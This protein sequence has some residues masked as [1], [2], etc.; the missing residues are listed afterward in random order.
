MQPYSWSPRVARSAGFSLIEAAVVLLI[1]G[2]LI[3][4]VVRPLL[5][6]T[7]NRVAEETRRVMADAREALLGYVVS[8]GYFPCP[9]DAASNGNEA[10]GTDHNTG[11]CPSSYGF[12]PAVSLGITSVDAQGYAVDGGRQTPNRVRYAVSNQTIVGIVNPFTTRFGMRR[13]G[14]T[15]LDGEAQFFICGSG[16]GVTAGADCGTAPTLTS[17]AVAVIWSS[18][19][20]A[21]A[22]GSSIHEAENPHPNGGSADRIFVNRPPSVASGEEFDDVLVWLPVS[23]IVNRLLAA[24]YFQ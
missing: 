14:A 8:N 23:I 13:V 24:G 12:L 21:A 17:S 15:L 19:S 7:E 16:I 10:S 3:G 9:A 1:M 11:F 18:G 2:I 22:G 4:T 6:D 20:N 5:A